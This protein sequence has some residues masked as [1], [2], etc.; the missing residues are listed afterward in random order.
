MERED[1]L[2]SEQLLEHKFDVVTIAK[3]FGLNVY[4]KDEVE[5]FLMEAAYKAKEYESAMATAEEQLRNLVQ[6]RNRR[7]AATQPPVPITDENL[8]EAASQLEADRKRLEKI[9]YHLNDILL[10]AEEKAERIENQA[11]IEATLKVDEAKEKAAL[12]VKNAQE[13]CDIILREAQE[14]MEEANEYRIQ[15]IEAQERVQ[16]D[17][18]TYGEKLVGF[19]ETLK[20]MASRSAK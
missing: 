6:D 9:Q 19:G 3:R 16:G 12:M 18:L 4:Q 20:E 5:K 2:L 1:L 15:W 8:A 11:Q 17:I 10:N 13:Q 7:V 14:R